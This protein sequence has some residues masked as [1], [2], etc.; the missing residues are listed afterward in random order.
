MSTEQLP[1]IMSFIGSFC[2]VLTAVIAI[3]RKDNT[4]IFFLSVVVA[5][6]T[7]AVGVQ[8]YV[9]YKNTNQELRLKRDAMHLIEGYPNFD[10]YYDERI[11]EAFITN[12]IGFFER[13]S[14]LNPDS[15]SALRDK[16][17]DSLAHADQSS[18]DRSRLLKEQA[19][20][21]YYILKPYAQ[22]D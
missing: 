19:Q 12:G 22:Q 16:F 14:D 5:I 17:R 7:L 21:L 9:I 8:S 1:H 4:I 13:Y 3:I 20:L 11:D 15:F 6:L 10:G 2:S 18:D